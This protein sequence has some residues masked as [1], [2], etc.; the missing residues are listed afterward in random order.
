[1]IFS[2]TVDWIFLKGQFEINADD[3]EENK[4]LMA[5]LTS[6]D[7]TSKSPP[8][9]EQPSDPIS[10]KNTSSSFRLIPSE[11]YFTEQW[12]FEKYH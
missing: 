1:M 5:L 9:D 11:V 6:L 3:Y 8:I 7:T 2:E 4:L 10:T 12:A